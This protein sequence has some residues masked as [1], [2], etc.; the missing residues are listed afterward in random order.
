MDLNNLRYTETHEWA[1]LDGD[2]VT[3][4]ITAFA[5]D[6]LVDITHLELPKVGT[7]TKAGKD[8]GNI[9]TVKSVNDLYAPVNGEIVET[10]PL[11]AKDQNLDT[12]KTDPYGQGWMVKIKLAAGSTLDHLMTKAAYDKQTADASH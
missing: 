1:A 9:E 4:G 6:Q 3:V 5:A 11:F 2:V 10:N 7:A 12:I 8:F